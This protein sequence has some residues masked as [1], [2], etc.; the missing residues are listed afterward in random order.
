MF[1][2]NDAD[3]L[4]GLCF[5]CLGPDMTGGHDST[6]SNFSQEGSLPSLPSSQ[7]TDVELIGKGE[8]CMDLTREN[9]VEIYMGV[10]ST[11]YSF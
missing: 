10:G 3:I 8:G 2:L 6:L 9:P 1:G 5:N 11:R 4:L 7:I